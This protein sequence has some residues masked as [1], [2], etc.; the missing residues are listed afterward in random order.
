[1][2][3]TRLLRITL[4]LGSIALLIFIIINVWQFGQT[5]GQLLSTLAGAWLLSLILRPMI[6]RL[7]TGIVPSAALIWARGR[8]GDAVVK[9]LS[10]FRL[11]F[12]LAVA[13]VYLLTVAIIIGGS[14]IAIAAILP[15]A[16]ALINQAPQIAAALPDQ[17]TAIWA[18]IGR[19]VGLDPNLITQF[20]SGQEFTARLGQ[21]AGLLAQQAVSIATATANFIGQVILILILS[22]YITNEGKLIERQFFALLP[23]SGHKTFEAAFKAVGESFGGY[24]RSTVVVMLI[25]GVS[26]VLIFAVL[27]LPFGV[28]VGAIF[29]VLSI[30]PLVGAPIGVLIAVVVALFVKPEVAIWVGV[31][32]LVFNQIVAYW[33]SPRLMQDTVGVPGLVGLVAV[34]LGVQLIGFWGLIFGVPIAGAAY[35]LLFDFWLPR[36]RVAQGLPD[37]DPQLEEVLG[38]KRK[39][40]APVV[41]EPLPS[42]TVGHPT[43]GPEA[44]VLVA[45]AP[46]AAAPVGRPTP[47]P[48]AD[49]R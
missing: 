25:G 41:P 46:V 37:R 33:I 28:A 12:G 14:T 45:A 36:R 21:L 19:Q 23:A 11:P 16:T 30:I 43:P 10:G 20:V 40:P 5:L 32:T 2:A 22:L 34:A 29:G 44:P 39:G 9:R 17:I 49:H 27:G 15:Q 6:F 4:S 13:V 35:A 3:P 18:P 31:T 7:R 47:G 8:Y 24:L 38:R 26:T 42:G 48:E 1:M